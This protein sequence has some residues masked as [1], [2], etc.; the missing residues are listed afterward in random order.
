MLWPEGIIKE[1]RPDTLKVG[2]MAV[3]PYSQ[4]QPPSILNLK[5]PLKKSPLYSAFYPCKGIF[6]PAAADFP[7]FFGFSCGR[8]FLC[9]QKFLKI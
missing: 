9:I 1:C 7:L 8:L 3:H 4:R 2:R 5:L 6:I